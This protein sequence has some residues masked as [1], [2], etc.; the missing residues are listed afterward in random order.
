MH[1]PPFP[2]APPADTHS[3][4]DVEGHVE[5]SKGA[6]IPCEAKPGILRGG[7]TQRTRLDGARVSAVDEICSSHSRTQALG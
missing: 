5:G 1:T 3:Q 7:V 2:F 6:P 4:D